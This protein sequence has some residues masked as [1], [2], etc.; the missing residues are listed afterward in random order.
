MTTREK[1]LEI[2][3]ELNEI[4]YRRIA[5][6]VLR[7]NKTYAEATEIVYNDLNENYPVQL[8]AFLAKI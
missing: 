1:A 3:A 6:L 4:I 7:K 2:K 8:A 5:G